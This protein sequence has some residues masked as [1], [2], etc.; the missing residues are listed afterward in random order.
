[1]NP[2]KNAWF[3]IEF[4]CFMS[5]HAKSFILPSYF[6]NSSFLIFLLKFRWF[7]T[8]SNFSKYWDKIKSIF[9][10]ISWSPQRTISLNLEY[11]SFTND[12]FILI[13]TCKNKRKI[14]K[15]INDDFYSTNPYRRSKKQERE[16]THILL[17]NIIEHYEKVI[18]K[19]SV[20]C[21]I[22]R[23]YF[24]FFFNKKNN[25]RVFWLSNNVVTK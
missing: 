13:F 21:W 23:E 7:L 3:F 14:T 19:T 18:I 5:Q 24:F 16:I 10:W 8:L 12:G 11:V 22:F 2:R 20:F 15:N 6:Q 17:W 9:R 25:K 4:Y 1:M